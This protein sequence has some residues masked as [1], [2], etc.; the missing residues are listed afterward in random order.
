MAAAEVAAETGIAV[1]VRERIGYRVPPITRAQ[2]EYFLC[3][4]LHGQPANLDLQ[5]NAEVAW[6]P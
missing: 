3:D 5:E 1:N 6:H 4:H 2:G